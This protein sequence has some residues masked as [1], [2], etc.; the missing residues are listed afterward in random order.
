MG[1]ILNNCYFWFV[2]KK[3]LKISFSLRAKKICHNPHKGRPVI[4]QKCKSAALSLKKNLSIWSVN[5][6]S[7][8]SLWKKVLFWGQRKFVTSAQGQATDTVFQDAA[9]SKDN[10]VIKVYWAQFHIHIN[11]QSLTQNT[12][13]IPYLLYANL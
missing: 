4:Q 6:F 10:P 8:K 12:Y 13:K 11:T 7:Q 1:K 3:A 2:R 9:T 5:N